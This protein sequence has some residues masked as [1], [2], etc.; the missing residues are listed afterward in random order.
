MKGLEQEELPPQFLGVPREAGDKFLDRGPLAQRSP[1]QGL[2]VDQ[3]DRQLGVLGD[4]G[5]TL[6]V[7]LRAGAF[8]TL[9]TL[10]LVRTENG[11]PAR[12]LALADLL[13]QPLPRGRAS[14]RGQGAVGV[15][16]RCFI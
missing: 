14:A 6:E 10:P 8:S 9:P 3:I 5:E 4:L 7:P 2:A 11:E 1:Q 16:A 13:S 15:D 12:S